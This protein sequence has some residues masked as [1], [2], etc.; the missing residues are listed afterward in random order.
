MR[1]N[2][3]QYLAALEKHGTFSRAA[4]ALY[5]SQP[6]ISVGIRELEEELGYPLLVRSNKGFSFTAEGLQVLDRA[7]TILN[8][9]EN[10]RR[11]GGGE[12]TMSGRVRIGSTPHFCNSIL[13]DVMLKVEGRW[14]QVSLLLEECDSESVIRMVDE[15]AL[16]M[17][18]IQLCDV[19]EALLLKKDLVFEELF[20][21]ELCIV[22]GE[23]H[24]LAGREQVTLDEVLNYPYA[25]Y[26]EAMNRQ[27]A[28]LLDGKGRVSHISEIVSL[29][30]FIIRTEHFT[31]IPRRAVL[32][33]NIV[34]QDKLVPLPIP[35]LHWKSRVGWIH[36]GKKLE[37]LEQ[38]VLEELI[39]RC[40][41][42]QE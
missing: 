31:V 19:D 26:K 36:T 6:S 34:Y 13:L 9:V 25:T 27:V 22:V 33:G 1:L 5:I 16:N 17:G 39:P 40:K 15:G 38:C 12:G 35:D 42:Y 18:L 29:R 11:I 37:P 4:Q 20:Q 28:R 21:E 8:E 32:Y 10:I 24:P 3:L 23:N 14:P 2:Q 41:E 7:K 30:Q